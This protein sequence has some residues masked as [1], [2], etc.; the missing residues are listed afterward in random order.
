MLRERADAGDGQV[1][2]QLVDVPVAVGVD[3]IDH[4]VHE[5]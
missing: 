2:L 3:E 5:N 1:L 4:F